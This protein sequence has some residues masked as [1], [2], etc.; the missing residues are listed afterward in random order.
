LRRRRNSTAT[1][2]FLHIYSQL[3]T[4]E[5]GVRISLPSERV[6]LVSNY[7]FFIYCINS[8]EKRRI[9]LQQSIN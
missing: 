3:L 1:K 6:R 9:K 7:F 8:L 5:R 4:I 2:G